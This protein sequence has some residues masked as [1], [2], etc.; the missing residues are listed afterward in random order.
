MLLSSLCSAA[1]V[2]AAAADGA[3][4]EPHEYGWMEREMRAE[5][6]MLGAQPS[7][8][9]AAALKA[10]ACKPGAACYECIEKHIAAVHQAGCAQMDLYSFCSA[11]Q[12]WKCAHPQPDG[13]CVNSDPTKAQWDFAQRAIPQ[14]PACKDCPSEQRPLPSACPFPA[15][16]LAPLSRASP[17]PADIVFSLTDDQDV[18]LGG[19]NPMKQT[20][21]LL[22]KSGGLLKNWRIHTPICSPSRSE[23]VSGRYFHNIK[24]PLPVPPIKLQPAATGHI[25]GSVYNNQSFAVYLRRDKGYNVGQ[26]GKSN[27]NTCEGFSRWFQGAFLGY[28]GGW[29]DNE[30]ANFSY[31]GKPTDCAPSTLS[32]P[33]PH[34][35]FDVYMV[36]RQMPQP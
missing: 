34:T 7:A 36:G 21:E 19:W 9:C 11:A 1:A 24:S 8:Q 22:Q 6:S 35:T 18:E 10:T 13:S 27:F 15:A 33:C 28:G 30:A 4:D 25:D 3:A 26:F 32:I 23:T 31:H 17:L 16:L 2:L 14:G 12:P 29:Q 20:Q 5:G